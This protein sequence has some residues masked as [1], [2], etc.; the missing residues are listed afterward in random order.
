MVWDGEADGKTSKVEQTRATRHSFILL[1]RYQSLFHSELAL[2][3]PKT[4]LS[5][6]SRKAAACIAAWIE[7]LAMEFKRMVNRGRPT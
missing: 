1:S 2:A 7:N 5:L 6:S 4:S 3:K